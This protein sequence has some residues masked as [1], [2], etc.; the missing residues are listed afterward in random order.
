MVG[1]W[2]KWNR[3]FSK[4]R[5][6]PPFVYYRGISSAPERNMGIYFNIVFQFLRQIC[7]QLLLTLNITV[8]PDTTTGYDLN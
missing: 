7:I 5:N 1:S 6:F 8:C 2:M 4:T 3:H